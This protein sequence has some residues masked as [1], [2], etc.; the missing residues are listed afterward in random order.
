[1]PQPVFHESLIHPNI[2]HEFMSDTGP[3][4]S[5][6]YIFLSLGLGFFAADFI[7]VYIPFSGRI[8]SSCSGWGY[9]E[10]LKPKKTIL[11]IVVMEIFFL[12]SY[13]G[14]VVVATILT[15]VGVEFFL[16]IIA[17]CYLGLIASIFIFGYAANRML[18]KSVC[19]N[20]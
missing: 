19:L 3:P 5:L 17:G 11:L 14:S 18:H 10:Y 7:F 8:P 13:G 6:F 2:Q 9:F 16:P 15:L 12:L 1:M 20:D 4:K